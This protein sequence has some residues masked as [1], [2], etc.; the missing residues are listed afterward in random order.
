MMLRVESDPIADAV[1]IALSDEPIGYTKELDDNRLVDYT[2]NP[3]KPV[4][5]DL[6]AVSAGVNLA[7]LPEA[8]TVKRVLE[9]INVNVY[10]G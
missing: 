8:E 2:M 7:N 3:G 6:L 4:G 10:S 1:Y 9:A 5:I